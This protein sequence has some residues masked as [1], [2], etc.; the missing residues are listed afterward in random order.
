MFQDNCSYT[1]GCLPW[2]RFFWGVFLSTLV[3]PL[4]SIESTA[5]I[6]QL[7]SWWRWR[8]RWRWWW[9]LRWWCTV[10]ENSSAMICTLS[11]API[12]SR[13]QIL[14]TCGAL[15]RFGK[16]EIHAP[17]NIILLL[18][19]IIVIIIITTMTIN[20][21]QLSM[22]RALTLSVQKPRA[23]GAIYF[24]RETEQS[25]IHLAICHKFGFSSTYLRRAYAELWIVL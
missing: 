9:W 11:I 18:L 5:T 17:I 24:S 20:W 4:Q 13:L 12:G 23:Q 8:W 22:F 2:R 14:Q 7:E 19:I 3:S 16:I 1:G 21:W 25:Q 6:E 15:S 10:N